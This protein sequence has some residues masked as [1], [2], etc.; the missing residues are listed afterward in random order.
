MLINVEKSKK[1]EEIERLG[2]YFTSQDL[3]SKHELDPKKPCYCGRPPS[4]TLEICPYFT[5]TTR[6]IRDD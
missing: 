1:Q 5:T 3:L 6:G 4:Y 2:H